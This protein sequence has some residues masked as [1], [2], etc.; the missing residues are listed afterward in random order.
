MFMVESLI[1]G[2]GQVSQKSDLFLHSSILF[3]LL[4]FNI[5]NDLTGNVCAVATNKSFKLK[6]HPTF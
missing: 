3:Y 1:F 2:V 6:S 5:R 4:A